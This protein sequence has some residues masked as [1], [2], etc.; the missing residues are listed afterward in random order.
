M[1]RNFSLA[2]AEKGLREAAE[3]Q[4]LRKPIGVFDSSLGNS[5]GMQPQQV[6]APLQGVGGGQLPTRDALPMGGDVPIQI[7]GGDVR[8]VSRQGRLAD[9]TAPRHEHHLA[10]EI[11]D[12]LRFKATG[13]D[14][15]GP[16][17]RLISTPGKLRA[18][19]LHPSSLVTRVLGRHWLFRGCRA[20]PGERTMR[21]PCRLAA[22]GL[23]RKAYLGIAWRGSLR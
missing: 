5:E 10:F 6:I 15:H 14:L 19:N 18:S 11:V 2:A 16:K 20:M 8:Q 3:P 17:I 9:L 22:C 7:A 21:G 12:Y 23:L 4:Q 1:R 13:G